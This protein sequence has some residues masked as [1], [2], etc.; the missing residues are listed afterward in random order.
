MQWPSKNQWGQFFKV[1]S[2]QEKILFSGFLFLFL[3]SLFF[4]IFQFYLGNTT[5]T[6]AAGGNYV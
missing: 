6:P 2:S 3:A 4:L 1:L 5:P